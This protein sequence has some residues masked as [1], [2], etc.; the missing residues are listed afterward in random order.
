M[1][2]DALITPRHAGIMKAASQPSSA[3]LYEKGVAALDAGRHADAIAALEE[4]L[5]RNPGDPST[6][7]ALGEA[8]SQIGLHQAAARF[9]QE[10]LNVAPERYDATVSL[11]RALAA[12]MRHGD[13]IEVLRQALSRTPEHAGLWLALGNAVRETGDIDNAVTFYREALRLNPDSIEARGNLADLVFD[14]GEVTEAL[15]L[16]DDALRRAPNHAQLHVNR[17][18]ALLTKGDVT[19]GWADYEWRLKIP[20]RRIERIGAPRLWDGSPRNGKRLLVMTEQGVGDQIAF[21]SFVPQLLADGPVVMECDKRLQPLLARSLPGATIHACAIRK[22]GAT[23]R[24]DYGWL[25]DA[26]G[27]DRSIDLA[28]LPYRCG[29]KPIDPQPWLTPDPAEA[30]RWRDWRNSL[31]HA[32]VVAVSWRSGLRGGLRDTQ[33]APLARWAQ[34]IGK[35]DAAIVSAQYGVEDG[36]IETLEA[37]SGRKLHVPPALDQK[38]ELDRTAAMLSVMDAAVSAPTAVAS[39]T[40]A[41]GVPTYKILHL[42]SWTAMGADREPFMPSVLCMRPDHAG[43]WRQVFERTLSQL[44][45]T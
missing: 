13:A 17:G 1:I 23:L 34:F 11:A 38:D 3:A 20:R 18:L 2:N 32:R 43:Q 33:Y 44:A 28:S 22:E 21:A 35:L 8:A 30:A 29:G 40:G 15:A 45:R 25:A 16:Y 5:K 12:L 27:A 41:L 26:G 9:F 6:L 7:F 14:A 24:A 42:A 36:E 4:A 39:I 19:A 10:V 31:G 37:L